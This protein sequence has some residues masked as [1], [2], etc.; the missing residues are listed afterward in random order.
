MIG[1][2]VIREEW[3]ASVLKTFADLRSKI[4]MSVALPLPL[5]RAAPRETKGTVVVITIV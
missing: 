1:D 4:G 2:V 3:N 5:L